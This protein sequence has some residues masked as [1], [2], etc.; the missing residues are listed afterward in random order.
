MKRSYVLFSMVCLSAV[1][2]FTACTQK[3]PGYK[4]T[5]N[6]LYYKFHSQ[7]TSATQPQLSDF[8]KVD[9]T[10]YLNDS[11]YY[12]WQGAQHEVYT[13]LR[14]PIFE[15][16]LQEAYA[17]MHVGDSA[18]FY[19]KADSVAALYYQQDPNVVGLKPDD[20]FR[21][22]VKLVEVKS[23]E[24]FMAELEMMKEVMKEA[25]K[26]ALEDYIAANNI[27]VTP[28]P[29]GAYIIPLEKG[30]GRCPVKGEKVEL[31]F[32]ATLLD[33]QSVGS[34]FDSPEKFSFV[35]GE[36][37]TIQGWE[38]VVPKMHLGERVTAIIPFDLAYG[39]RA[40]GS[41]PAYSNLVY[42]IKLLKITTAAELKAENEKAMQ[43]LKA[44]SE[45]AFF[46][47][48]KAN[49]ITDYTA[50]GLFFNKSVTTE[51]AQPQ[52]GQIARI[53]F[54][55]SYLNGT[56]L[57]D[58]EQLGDHYDVVIGEGKVLKGLEE[59]VTMMRVGEKARFVLPYT[60][61]YGTNAF[62]SI[63]A[64]SNLVFDVELLDVLNK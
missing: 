26:K 54:A 55:A 42:D 43:A 4:K 32:S 56:P 27:S 60:L 33:G 38:E 24:A 47:Y 58:S 45:K 53:K 21:Y 34:T 40:V 59:A 62:G 16:D 50:S 19:V 11:L 29:S 3:F 30:K 22:E 52:E 39:E 13:Q 51:G 5:Q 57:G 48:L 63:P 20:Y 37:N 18:S 8:L 17:M 9:M 15:G 49:N 61:A 36:G 14:D 44:D 1:M 35:L 64:Y 46:D 31:D 7:N 41:I 2:L 28:E 6:G 25:S 23:E 12:D 10:C